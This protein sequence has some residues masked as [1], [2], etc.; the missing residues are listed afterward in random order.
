VRGT[1][2]EFETQK[3]ITS[4]YQSQGPPFSCLMAYQ[5]WRTLN[6]KEW[7]LDDDL[8]MSAKVLLSNMSSSAD[9]KGESCVQ[10][11]GIEGNADYDCLSQ[12]AT[13][14]VTWSHLSR[15]RDTF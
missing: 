3:G 14:C 12:L 2:H 11:I 10:V 15:L 1:D 13:G 9:G 4:H 7:K 8:L 5:Y 6:M